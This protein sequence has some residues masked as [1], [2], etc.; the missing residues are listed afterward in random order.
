MHM[1][2]CTALFAVAA[3]VAACGGGQR[4]SAETSTEKLTIGADE[5]AALSASLYQMPTPN[6]LFSLVRNLMGE[7]DRKL[8]SNVASA[9]RY[10]TTSKRALNFG[11][12]AT[13]LVYASQF[14]R[15]EVA[16]YYLTVKDLGEKLGL[17]S[18][19]DAAI[20][21]RL[22]KNVSQGDSLEVISNEAYY[23]AYEKLQ[24]EDMGPA[25]SLVLAG[26]WV[27]SMHLVIKKAEAT[28][29]AV[30]LRQRVA[31]QK[32]T[33]EHLVQLMEEQKEDPAVAKVLGQLKGI[34][35]IYDRM[36][37]K[38]SPAEGKSSSGRMVLGDNTSVSVS[39]DLYQQLG[40]AVESV[41]A[42]I[43]APED[44]PTASN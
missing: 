37:V 33:L 4:P 3:L 27:E 18:A 20:Q 8:M 16:R 12:Y 2:T 38:R 36:E 17:S 25:L 26:G 14:N 44:A 24:D 35:D 22:D 21:S 29:N 30:E 9:D 42:A 23:K 28:G 13:D 10:V 43:V 34:R 40:A 31:D 39:E 6:E 5:G 19:F 15:V 7:G 1:K 11:V 41:R 32:P